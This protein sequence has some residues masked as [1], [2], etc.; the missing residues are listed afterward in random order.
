GPVRVGNQAWEQTQHDSYG[1]VILG[2]S[3]MFIDERLPG[4]GDAALFRRLEPLGHQAQAVY[5]EPDAGPWE[6][7]GRARIHTHSATMCWVAC[8]RLA[9][10]AGLLSLNERAGYWRE[11]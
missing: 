5:L 10:L 11:V 7:R 3:H 4:M 9:R 8:D 2:A 1:S 6:Y